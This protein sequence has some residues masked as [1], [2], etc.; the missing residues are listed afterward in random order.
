MFPEKLVNPLLYNDLLKKV[1]SEYKV[2][3]TINKESNAVLLETIPARNFTIW[4]S[5]EMVDFEKELTFSFKGK[6]ER[7]DPKPETRVILED[8]RGR[9]DRQHPFWMRADFPK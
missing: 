8:V 4:L 7:M 3:S 6:R 1:G 2:E 5:P 9:A